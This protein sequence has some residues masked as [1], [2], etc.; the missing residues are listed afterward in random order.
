MFI[1]KQRLHSLRPTHLE[2][3]PD[4]VMEIASPD[5]VDRDWREKFADY[6]AAGV[7]EYWIIDPAHQR[8]EAYQL[9]D[10]AYHSIVHNQGR[11]ASTV[12][13]G[14][15][16]RTELLWQEELPK[17]RDTL[18]AIETSLGT[19]QLVGSGG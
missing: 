11:V 5:S 14:F 12:L 8:V 15:F 3:P 16:L 13:A 10:G 9:V 18:K 6:Q 7:P 1:A 4:L 19:P 2:G 17:V